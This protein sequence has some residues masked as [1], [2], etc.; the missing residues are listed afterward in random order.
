VEITRRTRAGLVRPWI[1]DA[2]CRPHTNDSG[3]S[4]ALWQFGSEVPTLSRGYRSSLMKWL[5]AALLAAFLG[6]GAGV[7]APSADEV[8]FPLTIGYDV[9]LTAMRRQLEPSAGSGLEL[10][11]SP[12]GCGSF[13]LKDAILT[14]TDRR[15][16][17]AGPASGEAG[18]RFLG[19]CWANATWTG[20]VEIF[21]RPEIGADWQLRLRD[22]DIRLY[23]R[24]RRPTGLA[25]RLFALVKRWSEAELSRFAF[26]LGPPLREVS[27]LLT[28]FAG[29][30]GTTPLASA[31][32]TLRPD[33]VVVAPDAVRLFVAL[34][35]PAGVAQPRQ[36][37][38]VLTPAEI[39]RWE[40]RLDHW[41]GF[42][43]FVVKDLAGE[44]RDP[45]IREEL[46][47]LLLET[48]RE[49]VGILARGPEPGTDAVRRIFLSKWDRLRTIVQRT[50]AQPSNDLAK[51]FR[52]VTFLAAGDALA[53]IDVVAPAIGLD[54][55]ADGLRRLART[56][57]PAFVGDPVEQ[58]DQAD[59]RLQELFR[60]RDP[61][62]PPRRP[63]SQPRSRIWNLLAPRPAYADPDEW[64]ALPLRLDR[65]V[66]SADEL[67]VYRATVDRL[68]TLAAERSID[69]DRLEER[70]DVLFRNLVKATAW[71]ESCW[72]QF[73][74]HQ[75]R[76]TYLE[77][78][79]GDVGLMQINVRVWRGFFSATRLRWDA[80]YNAGAGAEILQQLLISYG[81]REAGTALE[82]A[83]RA[84]Y[85]AYQ[86]GP[87]GYRRYRATTSAPRG[88]A[89]DRS[90]WE[91]YQAVAAGLANDDVLCLGS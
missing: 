21:A 56:L 26:D 77:S 46:L 71:Q 10:W 91:K 62:A 7:P 11:R 37:E 52:Y 72:R 68:L 84:T 88:G 63:R 50:A 54:F 67:S 73:V 66:P 32:A 16:N 22:L 89:I 75:G 51:T 6:F 49:L 19:L 70:F 47:G 23:D 33:A 82:N 38:P 86:G 8:R 5:S 41:D 58:S 60:F 74:R 25:P 59:P 17:I 81:V 90:F 78:A 79:T 27:A 53:A 64:E 76:V 36:P 15:V 48:R 83:A 39:K 30:P 3:D 87:A 85:S 40:A 42:L 43:S 44:N 20:H 45:A 61:D 4:R 18:V 80:A 34:D 2:I 35:V 29:S 12:D 31:L 1:H 28:E 9:L 57:D 14:G 13:Q 24:N 55:S 69:P 65:W